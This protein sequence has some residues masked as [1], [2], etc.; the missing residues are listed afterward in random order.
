MRK[1]GRPS[2][3]GTPGRFSDAGLT[4]SSRYSPVHQV[5]PEI[6]GARTRGFRKPHSHMD[7][8]T[9]FVTIPTDG[10]TQVKVEISRHTTEPIAQEFDPPL[11]N[12]RNR[13]PPPSMDN[14]NRPIPGIHQECGHTIRHG[15]AQ[16]NPY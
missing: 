8:F 13:T 5:P 16:Q 7:L 1:E 4:Y 12:S 6:H 9:H 15:Y 10:R 11:Q 3:E 14:P 2:A